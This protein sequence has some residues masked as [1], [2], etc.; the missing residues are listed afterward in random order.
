MAAPQEILDLVDRFRK[1]YQS[2]R[3]PSYNETQVRR[4]FIDPMFRSLGWDVDNTRGYAEAYKEVIHEDSI[5][6]GKSTKAPDYSFRIGG[7]RKFFVETKKPSVNVAHDI[8]PAYQ[9]RRYAWSAKLPLSILTD[10]EELAI[11]DCRVRPERSDKAATA[12]ILYLTY[13]D[14]SAKWDDV[15]TIFSRE[16]VL[17]GSFDRF[18]HSN[19]GKRGTAQVDDVF[20][21]EIEAWRS[22]LARNFALRNSSLSERDLNHVVQKTIDRVIFL[23]IC[24]DRGIEKYG[25]LQSLLKK[26]DLYSE[27]SKLF[28]RA[29]DRYN[30]GLF[31]FSREKNRDEPP[32][33]WTLELR[34]DDRVVK[35][36]I[37]RLY[38]PESPYEFS[39]V[40][41][42][43]LG[44]VYEQFLGKV[45]RLT[46]S[47]RAVIEAKPEVKKSG[48]VYY[49]PSYV[50]DYIVER[51]IGDALRD[52]SVNEVAGRTKNWRPSRRQHPLSILD[53][54]CGSGSFLL[55]AYQYLLDWYLKRYIDEG[56]PKH[57]DR[58][59]QRS[60]SDWRLTTSERKR[61]LLDHIFGVDIDQQAVEVTKLS[62]LLKVLEGENQES[63][64]H[65]LS[66]F[67]ER[68][69]PDLAG[70]IK[71]GNSLISPDFYDGQM[72]ETIDAATL[73]SVNAFDWSTEFPVHTRDIGFDAIVG[74]PPYIRI[75][76]IPHNHAD[77]YFSKYKS[78]TSKTDLSLL[79]LER[80]LEILAPAGKAGFICTSQ[81]LTTDYGRKLRETLSDGRL[82]EIVDFGSLPVFAQASTYPA[83]FVLSPSSADTVELRRVHDRDQLNLHS[84][85]EIEPTI[86]ETKTLGSSPWVTAG[87]DLHSCL[88]EKRIEW[89]PLGD[90]GGTYIGTKS[91]MNAAFVM[92]QEEARDRALEADLLLPYAYKG[93]EVSRYGMIEPS[94]CIIY[95]Y[96]EG[97][98]GQPVL[99]S[100]TQ[101]K[102]RFP[103]IHDYLSGHRE[104]LSKRLDSRRP[105]AEGSN[106]FRHLRPGSYRYIRSNKLTIKG[107]ARRLRTGLL[108]HE[109]AF[110]GAN[111][112]SVILNEACPYDP[113]FIL[114][115][116]NSR[117]MDY[118]LRSVCPPKL[119]GYT[120]FSSSYISQVPL[121][122]IKM[123]VDAERQ[124]HDKLADLS[125]TMVRL[126]KLKSDTSTK[127][128]DATVQRQIDSIDRQI[129]E[130][131]YALYE[132][133]DSEVR[134]IDESRRA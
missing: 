96:L 81:W 63:L 82:R 100:E 5:K 17:T 58:L 61:I 118:Y 36:M 42:D 29:D 128:D 22:I 34:L 112:P 45:I 37:R 103:R 101:L 89:D 119:N 77:Y 125:R 33:S 73:R 32:D 70:N 41:A 130:T 68:A 110:D 114:G 102:Q 49:T 133:T 97:V 21:A 15:S 132:F 39:V 108:P 35:Q 72:L 31:H 79:F 74:N 105:Y 4:E 124:A 50:V 80:A 40:S 85:R 59:F 91:G 6:V 107:I 94:A 123:D 88:Q 86:L 55:G 122:R 51:T 129:D 11:Y 52:R 87:L 10:F 16:A 53:P 64:E 57:K 84:L 75:Q 113:M 109:S 71:C 131:V 1:Q 7:Q 83:V 30:S 116:L 56:P 44:Q 62:L 47:H 120:R 43:I 2:Y 54:A 106:W 9:L 69:L 20:L 67:Q 95:P 121:K 28:R 117:L 26:T 104:A 46:T 18:A 27:L 60:A 13:E 93:G 8:S 65:Q 98:E 134:T 24:E 76:R 66:L 90:F 3:L 14:Y 115:L 126:Y 92:T 38:Y 99:L 127:Y 19:L 23:R 111:C 48:G 78:P 12:R 25:T